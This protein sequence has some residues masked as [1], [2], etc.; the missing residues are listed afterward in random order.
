MP[1][2]DLFLV[3]AFAAFFEQLDGTPAFAHAASL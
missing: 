1:I 3:G 2:R